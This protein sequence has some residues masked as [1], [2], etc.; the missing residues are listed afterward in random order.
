MKS[1]AIEMQIME[2]P[3]VIGIRTFLIDS[4]YLDSGPNQKIAEVYYIGFL[5]KIEEAILACKNVIK[6]IES[7]IKRFKIEFK[8]ALNELKKFGTKAQMKEIV[9]TI[10]AFIRQSIL[11]RFD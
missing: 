4:E 8:Y 9:L 10:E 3:S 1:Y 6:V 11:K 7:E 5:D 2:K